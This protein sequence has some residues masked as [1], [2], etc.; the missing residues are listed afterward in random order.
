MTCN[1]NALLALLAG[2]GA[3]VIVGFAIAPNSGKKLRGAIGN[4]VDDCLDSASEKAG[5]LRKSA[6]NLAQ[7]GLREV[8]KTA[9]NAGEKIK[10]MVNGASDAANDA[11]DIGATKG[12]EVI[13]HTAAAI[14]TGTRS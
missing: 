1:K 4:T 7:R 2:V 13:D 3:G 6:A 10:D 5:E 8:H 9:N 14:R 11:L 12:H